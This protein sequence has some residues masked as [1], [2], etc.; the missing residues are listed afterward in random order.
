MD[1]LGLKI[2]VAAHV[3]ELREMA[4]E[5]EDFAIRLSHLASTVEHQYRY[6]RERDT[7]DEARISTGREGSGSGG[8]GH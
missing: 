1:E 3:A 4:K 2:A 8:T 5:A 6:L 7:N